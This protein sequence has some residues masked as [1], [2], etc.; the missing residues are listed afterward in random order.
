MRTSSGKLCYL[1]FGMCVSV[2]EEVR[3]DL[4]TAIVR[5][6]NRDFDNLGDSFVKLGFLPVDADTS[7]LAPLLVDAFGDASTGDSLSDLSFSRLANNLS[8]VAFRTPIRIPVSFTLIIRQLITLEGLALQTD[9]TFK[10]VDEAYPYVVQRILTDDSPVFQAA[11]QDVLINRETGRLR[12]NR[13]SALLSTSNRSNS[14]PEE[15][16]IHAAQPQNPSHEEA[17]PWEG[18]SNKA[19]KRVAD[20]ALS[21]RGGFLRDALV[22][23]VIDTADAVQ[24]TIQKRTSEVTRGIFPAPDEQ[25]DLQRVEQAI[26]ISKLIRTKGP[27]FL[28]AVRANRW[29]ASSQDESAARLQAF[30]EQFTA[31]SRV[32]IGNIVE[33]NSRRI[34]RRTISAIFGP[35]KDK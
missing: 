1:D 6:V 21:D 7:Q 13:L 15:E 12:W 28:E 14:S 11:L 4:I 17:S 33:R 26:Q 9:P 31:A 30:Q 8:G 3:N 2:P 25:I 20:F 27:N 29:D 22:Q 32:V 19:L 24:L 16:S 34:L 5:L 23:E 10:I 18:V 35:R